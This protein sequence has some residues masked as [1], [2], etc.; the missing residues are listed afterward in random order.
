MK[1]KLKVKTREYPRVSGE[2]YEEWASSLDEKE[3][4]EALSIL[5]GLIQN[6]KEEL[7]ELLS[8]RAALK[9]ALWELE[10][11]QKEKALLLKFQETL[12]KDLV[13]FFKDV[14]GPEEGLKR[15]ATWKKYGSRWQFAAEADC[16]EVLRAC[17]T[18]GFDRFIR[19]PVVLWRLIVASRNYKDL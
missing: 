8:K 13:G 10:L 6:N 14:F 12:L 16:Q 1:E 18:Q 17:Q 15:L 19:K 3:L 9:S 4:K 7:K 2:K 11:E 5:E